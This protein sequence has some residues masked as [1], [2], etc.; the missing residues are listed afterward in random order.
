MSNE[1]SLYWKI[2]AAVVLIILVWVV[3]ASAFITIPTGSVGIET[4]FGAATGRVY[5]PGLQFKEPLVVDIV[6]F[7]T[8]NQSI[9]F[10]SVDLTRDLQVVT[11]TVTINY[12]IDP[13][14]AVSLYKTVGS[15]YPDTIVEPNAGSVLHAQIGQYDVQDLITETAV[16]QNTI[17]SAL[18]NRPQINA[19]KIQIT[20]VNMTDNEFSN[21]F[22]AA[23]EAKQVAQQTL[24]RVTLEAQQKV[25]QANA[26]AQAAIASAQ[27]AA[28][29]HIDTAR[30]NAQSILLE[31]QANAAAQKEQAATLSSLYNQY[32]A[33]QKWN[34]S[35]P[36]Y[37]TGSGTAAVPFINIGSGSGSN[38]SGSSGGSG[39]TGTTSKP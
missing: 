19:Y 4:Q 23:V 30:G 14:D 20:S 11:S 13:A 26:D 3:I 36:L 18:K 24:A 15:D 29:A 9:K 27:G 21:Q 17:Q 35:V 37:S 6:P 10:T 8:R 28:T 34:G 33:I 12:Q 2:A 39:A 32:A 38:G 16:V 5:Q 25:V 31:A 1:S 7:N 22:E